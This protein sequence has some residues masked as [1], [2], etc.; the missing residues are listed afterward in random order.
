MTVLSTYQAQ[1]VNLIQS[2]GS[3]IPLISTAQST[4][5]INS[6]RVQIAAEAKCIRNYATLA[7]VVNQQQYNFSTIVFAPATS[8]VQ[9]VMNVEMAG[10]TVPAT[11][12]QRIVVQREWAWF[13]RY[14]LQN[15][16]PVAGPPRYWAQFGQGALGTLWFNLPD[17]TYVIN[18]DTVCLPL[19]LATDTDP[20]AIPYQWTDAVPFYAAWL[21]MQQEQRQGDA[22]MML[23]R[24]KMLMQRA[25]AA[26]TPEVTPTVYSQVPDVTMANQL[27][28]RPGGG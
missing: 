14:V 12:G 5:Y 22:E 17:F 21:G 18:L 1:F 20:E 25:R 27:G 7:L 6:A 24:F 16:V 13:N 26:A 10:F 9:V 8:G 23:Q 4:V 11:T 2:L 28:I 3:P 19:P 15:P